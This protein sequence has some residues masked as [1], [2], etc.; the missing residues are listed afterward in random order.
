TRLL[1]TP[2]FVNW[3]AGQANHMP[4]VAGGITKVPIIC[5]IA[6]CADGAG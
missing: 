6:S 2:P 3:S 1:I 4:P 5:D